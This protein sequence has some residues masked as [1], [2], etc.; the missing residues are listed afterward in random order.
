[1]VN[2]KIRIN[3]PQRLLRYSH[4]FVL[5]A[6][7]F[8]LS[9]VWG[10][11]VPQIDSPDTKN[12]TDGESIKEDLEIK[13]LEKEEP[14][15]E[16]ESKPTILEK[17]TID[18]KDSRLKLRIGGNL[19]LDGGGWD[20]NSD[21]QD[22]YGD[23][24]WDTDVRKAL[25]EA[26]AQ[27]NQY[28]NATLQ[29][30]L[31]SGKLDWADVYVEREK[32]PYLGTLRI[33]NFVEPTSL[34]RVTSLK[35]QTFMERSLANALTPGRNLGGTFSD[36]HLDGRLQW[37]AG[38]FSPTDTIDSA[39]EVDG[40]GYVLRVTG[41][42]IFKNKG[43]ELLHVGLSYKHTDTDGSFSLRARPESYL[44]P[45]YLNT[46]SLELDTTDTITMEFAYVRGP[47]SF[48]SEYTFTYLDNV[49]VVEPPPMGNN[50]AGSTGNST[51]HGG[52]VQASYFLTG[53]YRT[54]NI[55][56]GAFGQTNPEH[57]WTRNSDSSGK[58]AVE[59]AARLSRLDLNSDPIRGGVEKNATLGVNWYINKRV[60]FT[61][62]YTYADID[63]DA[64]SGHSHIFQTRIQFDFQ[65]KE[66]GE[67]KTFTPFGRK[68]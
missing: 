26:K 52:Y 65:G 25:I 32:I 10:E 1:M 57:P 5:T 60:R 58:G 44:A 54:Y 47:W 55:R 67:L 33:G 4:I 35:Y 22:F 29:L 62:N 61:V 16:I 66:L 6:L 63:T 12:G 39:A 2:T 24:N 36:T 13:T 28:F 49:T 11:P 17:L 59:L 30:E 21:I 51:L 18:T 20:S 46:G 68:R 40:I 27:F 14:G 37:A 50:P 31:D 48:Q 41:L 42:P 38:I 23:E 64:A 43:A 3:T 8:S 45:R 19:L 15:T 9:L 53:E 56:K 7:S 34:E